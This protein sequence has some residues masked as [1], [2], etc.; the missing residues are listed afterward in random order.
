MKKQFFLLGAVA[1]FAACNNSGSSDT[2]G[3][4]TTATTSST[5]TIKK[6]RMISNFAS[7]SFV[8]L[9]TNQ[10][11]K[12]V[13]DTVHYY[14][15]DETTGKE[16]G[17]YYDPA[18]HDTFDYWG[19]VVNHA[20]N[21]TNNDYTIDETRLPPDETMN[22]S[23]NVNMDTSTANDI[24]TNTTTTTTTSDSSSRMANGKIKTKI[25]DDKMKEKVKPK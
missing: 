5:T 15:I 25:K 6:G 24:T 17:F 7:R 8:D 12:L 13:W 16:P 4:D 20:L 22:S 14:Y 2:S 23:N 18:A 1:L 10:P 9:K 21:Y 19:R 11:I 3:K